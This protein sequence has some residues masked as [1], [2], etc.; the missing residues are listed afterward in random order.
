MTASH[1]K[2][3]NLTAFLDRN[4]LQIDGLT[5]EVMALEPLAGKWKAFGWDVIEID[6]HDFNQIIRALDAP[7]AKGRPRMIIAMTTKG[8]GVSFMENVVD[9][10]GRAPTRE[11][12]DIAIRELTDSS[13]V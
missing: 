6:G 12:H 9:F 11:E 10:H 2:L 1:Y 5:E 13:K 4:R 8:K 7:P 3:D